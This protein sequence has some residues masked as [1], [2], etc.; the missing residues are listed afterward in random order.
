MARSLMRGTGDHVFLVLWLL[1][2]TVGGVSAMWRLIDN[3]A[4][5]RHVVVDD[6]F[7]QVGWT[8]LGFGR[9]RSFDLARIKNLR[10]SM[11]TVAVG[12]LKQPSAIVF[13]Y[14]ARTISALADID[15]VEATE[16]VEHLR[17]RIDFALSPK[18]PL[19]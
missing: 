3:L 13:D 12:E 14:E 11:K 17:E 19:R 9:M 2:W 5:R 1:G 18:L 7:L 15:L 8:V 4:L 6:R 16:L 10:V